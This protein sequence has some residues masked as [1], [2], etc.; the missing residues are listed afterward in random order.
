M[1]TVCINLLLHLKT[2][3]GSGNFFS[4]LDVPE[5]SCPTRDRGWGLD[6]SCFYFV[7]FYLQ[8]GNLWGWLDRASQKISKGLSPSFSQQLTEETLLVVMEGRK[9]ILEGL[10]SSSK[11][12]NL[13]FS[14][15]LTT[16]VQNWSCGPSTLFP[17]GIK[18]I[19]A[20]NSIYLGMNCLCIRCIIVSLD[21]E[22]RVYPA[23][24][25]LHPQ[26]HDQGHILLP[27]RMHSKEQGWS[28]I[29]SFLQD[30][31]NT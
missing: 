1:G 30:S 6:Q 29:L 8:I 16:H 14:V 22:T 10:T 12:S 11:T 28:I 21:P 13:S 3:S 17:R 19:M 25:C 18:Q 7:L 23:W 5:V 20:S 4:C 15:L 9:T 27:H 24:S 31:L 26:T 2:C